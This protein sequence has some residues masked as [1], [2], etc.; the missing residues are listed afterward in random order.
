MTGMMFALGGRAAATSRG[1]NFKDFIKISRRSAS[2]R[3]LLSN[4]GP[5]AYRENNYGEVISVERKISSSGVSSYKICSSDNSV[6]SKSKEELLYILDHFNIQIDNPITILTQECTKKFLNS[7]DPKIK[8]KLFMNA[9]NLHDV[10]Q[11]YLDTKTFQQDIEKKL[12]TKSTA[13]TS[14]KEYIDSVNAKLAIATEI[15]NVDKKLAYLRNKLLS[16]EILDLQ[17]EKRCELQTKTTHESELARLF[18][19]DSSISRDLADEEA[20]YATL[21]IRAD[22]LEAEIT[23]LSRKKH[24]QRLKSEHHHNTIHSKKLKISATESELKSCINA[25]E[26]FKRLMSQ[27]LTQETE[28][29]D[30]KKRGIIQNIDS[31]KLETIEKQQN[32]ET[33][34]QTLQSLNSQVSGLN[35]QRLEVIERKT[36]LDRDL[37]VKQ[38]RIRALETGF[39]DSLNI[40]G[41]FTTVI[42]QKI[43]EYVKKRAFSR[44]PLG[45]IGSL[46]TVKDKKW[47]LSV[48]LCLKDLLRAFIVFSYKDKLLLLKLFKETCRPNEVPPI[49]IS[50]YQ[51]SLY[52]Y[53]SRAPRTAFPTMLELIESQHHNLLNVLIDQSSIERILCIERVSNARSVMIPHPPPH[54]HKAY[55]S[56]GD[57]IISVNG[58]ARFYSTYQKR[59]K[60]LGND[61]KTLIET[62]EVEIKECENRQKQLDLSLSKIDDELQPLKASISDLRSQERES[63]NYIASLKSTLMKLQAELESMDELNTASFDK[64]VNDL[65][66]K[67]SLLQTTLDTENNELKEL[68]S[69]L[70]TL[71]NE[72]GETKTQ[73]L[74]VKRSW[75]EIKVSAK[76]KAQ[77]VSKLKR[78]I[79]NQTAQSLE[80]Q[81]KVNRS[82]KKLLVLDRSISEKIRLL[83]SEGLL[84]TDESLE[85]IRFEIAHLE[86]LSTANKINPLEV[87]KLRKE[88]ERVSESYERQ[89]QSLTDLNDLNNKLQDMLKVRSERYQKLRRLVVR[90]TES[91]FQKL[92]KY[93][94]YQGS[95]VFDHDSQKLAISVA[96]LGNSTE[97]RD[98]KGLSGG[99]RSFSTLALVASLWQSIESPFRVLDEFDV[100]MDLINRRI[101]LKL[102]SDFSSAHPNQQLIL[103]TPQDVSELCTNKD[104]T[105]FKMESPR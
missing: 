102:L 38:Q 90:R 98:T 35:S 27:I 96:A 15:E 85:N 5:D 105:V 40:F 80:F 44:Q 50:T 94:G 7:H 71:N 69:V 99:E 24:D 74:P 20:C 73:I 65:Q 54:T 2:V 56:E 1:S 4:R 60:L 39:K 28:D 78:D 64:E 57:E 32:L 16:R 55:T 29:R 53:R 13:L 43:K 63:L 52:D 95:L 9:T 79:E 23:E 26:Q 75:D 45:P 47:F 76:T 97:C 34:N 3:I 41:S 61:P 91:S 58:R 31:Y 37:N 10:L 51:N 30:I 46:I 84:K 22:S 25:L 42:H 77:I 81:Q 59:S 93:R 19:T 67:I 72:Y 92:L 62:I 87:S 66:S 14:F 86:K 104:V 49:V 83:S 33:L 103:I 8:Y 17:A 82:D 48:E 89:T 6:V 18:A 12:T 88:Y 68:V 70:A 11:Y 21:L 100:F 36:Q 101:S